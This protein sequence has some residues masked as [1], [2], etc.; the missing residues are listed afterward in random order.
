[1]SE[2]NWNE[3]GL[4]KSQLELLDTVTCS[5]TPGNENEL[6][7]EVCQKL[8]TDFPSPN[9]ARALW[10]SIFEKVDE[11][12]QL[13][14]VWT[15]SLNQIQNSNIARWSADKGIHD[16]EEFHRWSTESPEAFWADAVERLNIQFEKRGDVVLE[17]GDD[18]AKST[19]FSDSTLN[20]AK[21]CFGNHPQDI[22]IVSQQAE[23]LLQNLTYDEL[24][25][26]VNRIANGLVEAG[27][28]RG[29]AIAVVLPMTAE[30]V[31]IYLGIVS[32]GMAVVSIADSFAA[33]EITNR[34]RI[35]DAKAV[36]T[37]DTMSRGGKQIPLF[38]RVEEATDLPIIVL[39]LDGQKVTCELR[40]QDVSYGD[41]ISA[42]SEFSPV[43]CQ[44]DDAINILFSS[45]TTG[46]PKAIP[47]THMTPIKC[48]IDGF[49]H[50]NIRLGTV[51][52]W[53]T[54]LGWMMG[55]WLIF[56]TLINRGTIALYEDIPMGEGF[57]KFVQDAKVNMLGVV[58]TIV[59]AWRNKECMEPFDWSP[60]E[61][62]SSTGEASQADDMFYLS[63]L[64]DMKPIVEYCGGTEIGGGYIT[65]TV[66]QPNVA[67]TFSTPAIGLDFEILDESGQPTDD[68]QIFLRGPS[69]GLSERLLNRDHFETYYANTPES[70]DGKRL[71]RH[72]DQMKRLPGGYFIAGGRADDTM[73]LGGIKVSS[74]EIERVLNKINGVVETA[75]VASPESGPDQLIVFAVLE[76]TFERSE[77]QSL[78]NSELRSQLNPLFKVSEI[79]IIESMPRTA[80]NKVMRR[81]LRD[82]LKDNT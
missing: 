67:A 77:L 50:Q 19:W 64:A 40:G 18:P 34:L 2:L 42:N 48:A 75:A 8:Q 57:G 62:F 3:I 16:F 71:R 33:N 32:A 11:S 28:R 13:K 41:F 54:N 58:P 45:G 24:Q 1:M 51:A 26:K 53:P 4:S 81:K 44:P 47:W 29:D 10:N 63:A 31:A 55:P 15:P 70:A 76:K 49:V 9:V 66:V 56:A 7:H 60:I 68:G 69:V 25:Q 23:R 80:S 73:N 61:C 36:F 74:A 59:K 14:P 78:M 39:P 52:A 38:D 37:Y 46:D 21:S 65:S 12:S 30:S 82:Q 79:H 35:A 22:A 6:W 43:V 20:I 27:Y 72:G 17:N 5:N